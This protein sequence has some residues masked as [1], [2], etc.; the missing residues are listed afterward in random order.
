LAARLD[1]S[2]GGTHARK[3]LN[4]NRMKG[5]RPGYHTHPLLEKERN[6]SSDSTTGHSRRAADL[7]PTWS[8]GL[9]RRARNS[10]RCLSSL[11][12]ERFGPIQPTTE[13]KPRFHR[14]PAKPGVLS[15]SRA[16]PPSG[17]PNS[18]LGISGRVCRFVARLP[19]DITTETW[20][21]VLI[22]QPT[23]EQF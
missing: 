8:S 11:P 10:V 17:D 22:Y 6:K 13:R 1:S 4:L 3:L 18:S 5:F 20:S 2:E 19:L 21:L 23:G 14:S 16:E 9:S 15:D 7:Q 12:R